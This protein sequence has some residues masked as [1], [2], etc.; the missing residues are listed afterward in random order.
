MT[1]R[2][3]EQTRAKI[4]AAAAALFNERGYH[5]TSMADIMQ[6]TG[7]TKGGIYGNFRREGLNK[8][9]VKEEIAIAAFRHTT[10]EVRRA[11]RTR[12]AV[13]RHSVDKLKA[14]VYFYKEKILQPPL[15]FGC[16][17]QNTIVDVT[18]TELAL[19]T[20]AREEL[21]RW[22]SALERTVAHGIE[23]GEIRPEVDPVELAT[24]YIG[25]LEGGIFLAKLHG[26]RSVFHVLADQLL[27]R[28]DQLR[29][30]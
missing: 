15:T 3:S 5:G 28:L 25:M 26:D 9:G 30:A 7:L 24:T 23:A 20:C 11:I 12:T 6:A 22:Q 13:I 8:Q 21:A 17:I 10:D 18:N 2:K 14:A 16:P 1:N 29:T 4:V 27:D 19:G